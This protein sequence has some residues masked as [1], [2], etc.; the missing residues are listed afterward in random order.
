MLLSEGLGLV[1]ELLGIVTL[2][3]G[4]ALGVFSWQ[5]YIVFFGSMTFALAVLTSAAVLMEDIST[6]AYRLRHIVRLLALGP[7]ELV[8]YR[9]ILMWA[10]YRG[11]VGFLRSEKGWDKFDRNERAEPALAGADRARALVAR[12]LIFRPGLRS[13]GTRD[14]HGRA[15]RRARLARRPGVPAC[16]APGANRSPGLS[17]PDAWRYV[18]RRA[19]SWSRPQ[20]RLPDVDCGRCQDGQPRHHLDDPRRPQVWMVQRLPRVA[21]QPLHMLLMD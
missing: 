2:V 14:T 18:R 11:T 15:E 3:A 16:R 12:C 7:L 13:R 20:T 19:R 8:V 1:F 6:R 5:T 9:P 21:R 10:R 17:A 4:I